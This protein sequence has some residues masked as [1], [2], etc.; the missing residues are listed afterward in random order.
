MARKILVMGLPGAGKTTLARMLAPLVNAVIFNADDVRSNINRD[1]GFSLEDRLEHARRM[2]WMCDR[3]VESGGIA[4]A[5]FICPT[6]ETRAAFNADYVVWIDRI[7]EGRFED[8]NRLFAAPDRYDVRVTADGSPRHWA[9]RIAAKLR[10]IF[11]P[12]RPTAL[13]LGRFQ[14]FHD[15]HKRLIEVGLDRVGQACL[16]VRD[17]H[18]ADENN[19]LSFFEVKQ[20]IEAGLRAYDG[21]FVVVPLPNITNVF[22]GRDV[23][24]SV[25]RIDLD[26]ATHAISATDIR[27]DIAR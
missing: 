14:P 15:G 4:I 21:R 3:V 13:F 23:G 7:K 11:D 25:Q 19:P 2:G 26:E 17:T 20:R 1:L 22:Y 8:T 24:Y 27:R 12:Q 6:A 16:A 5:D 9:E 10:P 18:G